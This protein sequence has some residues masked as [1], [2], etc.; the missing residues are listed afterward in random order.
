MSLSEERLREIEERANLQCGLDGDDA[1]ELLIE[2]KRLRRVVTIADRVAMSVGLVPHDTYPTYDLL[3]AL[4]DMT[5]QRDEERASRKA[6][7]ADIEHLIRTGYDHT[8]DCVQ[9][10]ERGFLDWHPDCGR[11]WEDS[12]HDLLDPTEGGS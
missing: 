6:L 11:C 7:R 12:L 2:V 3:A 10:R 8:P 5:R 9:E 4:E 1:D